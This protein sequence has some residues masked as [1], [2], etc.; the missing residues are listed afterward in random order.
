MILYE[1][2]GAKELI[3]PT[4]R[5]VPRGCEMPPLSATQQEIN[6]HPADYYHTVTRKFVKSFITLYN[7]TL[8][9]E[10]NLYQKIIC[11][12]KIIEYSLLQEVLYVLKK[13]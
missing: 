5:H 6:S 4:L 8:F 13:T 3:K 10:K 1:K 2:K 7:K 11:E 12:K 9:S